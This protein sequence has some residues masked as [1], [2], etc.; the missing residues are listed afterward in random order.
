MK[1]NNLVFTL[2]LLN[3]FSYLYGR[4]TSLIKIIDLGQPIKTIINNKNGKI[5]VQVMEKVYEIKNEKLVLS[6]IKVDL[7]DKI[8]FFDGK[9]TSIDELNKK[10]IK[11]PQKFNQNL[12]W[13]KFLAYSGT[14]NYCVV[15]NDDKGNYWVNNGSKFLYCFRI[16]NLFERSLNKIS[17]RGIY[18]CEND[19]YTNTYSGFFKNGSKLSFNFENGSSNIIENS[20]KIYFA[21]VNRIYSLNC[22][23]EKI[24]VIYE[25]SL[26]KSTIE[27]SCIEFFDNKFWIGS[28]NG[29]FSLNKDSTLKREGG[30]KEIIHN[31]RIIGNKLFICTEKCVYIYEDGN[32]IKLPLLSSS[33]R[34]N[35]IEEIN[36]CF[37]IASSQ[38][39]IYL[40]PIN[41]KLKKVFKNSMNELKECFSIEKDNYGYLWIGTISGIT[42]YNCK[43]AR[44]EIFYEDIEFNKRSSFKIGDEFYFGSTDGFF[45]FSTDKFSFEDRNLQ[46]NNDVN[47]RWLIYQIVSFLL[48]G[49]CFYIYHRWKLTQ[50]I[51]KKN[52]EFKIEDEPQILNSGSAYTISNIEKYIKDHIEDIT[53]EKLREDS[54]YTK[55]V[56]YRIFSQHYDITP[57]Q[58]IE[59]IKEEKFR[60]R[61]RT[62]RYK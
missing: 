44:I 61:K 12:S 43:T 41:K 46:I 50:V 8:F 9:L 57:K 18:K 30:I 40:D 56:F 31:F 21:T 28:S 32:F 10:N 47:N 27:I 52:I 42:R 24:E 6:K 2:F 48:L 26:Y 13:N 1:Q 25:D 54:G 3:I 4:D 23:N 20:G 39:L 49:F 58:L 34:Y 51:N 33:F 19:F 14:E 45:K 38:G 5:L 60:K 15:S 37:Y 35:D 22:K 11:F 16:Q 62:H 17:T 53:V 59:S 36:G 55:N 29:L 7:N